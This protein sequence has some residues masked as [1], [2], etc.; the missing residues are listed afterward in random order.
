MNN[1]SC[2][3][4]FLCAQF[5]CKLTFHFRNNLSKPREKSRFSTFSVDPPT[6]KVVSRTTFLNVE[7]YD[8]PLRALCVSWQPLQ[9]SNVPFP[10][11]PR[12]MWSTEL[13]VKNAKTFILEKQIADFLK[14]WR[15]MHHLKVVLLPNIPLNQAT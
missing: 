15:N 8:T 3:F 9:R 10:L 6:H 1:C 4:V 7:N 13:T 12:V 2:V 5:W 14:D 11:Y